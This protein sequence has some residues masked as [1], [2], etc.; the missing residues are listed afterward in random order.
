MRGSCEF[1]MLPNV[2]LR[3]KPGTLKWTV[4]V[5]KCISHMYERCGAI[6]TSKSTGE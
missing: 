2:I 6:M 3:R 5:R 4:L 1:H